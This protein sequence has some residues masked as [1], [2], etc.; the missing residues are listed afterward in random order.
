MLLRESGEHTGTS[1]ELSG[2]LDGGDAPG[3][4]DA[5][6]LLPFADAIVTRDAEATARAREAVS[7]RMG[8]EAMVDVAAVASNFERMTRIADATGIPLGERLEEPTAQVREQ[9]DLARFARA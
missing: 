8:D 1:I 5:D 7:E 2:V 6:V 9:L 3:V 4:A